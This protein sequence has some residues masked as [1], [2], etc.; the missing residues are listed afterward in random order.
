[1]QTIYYHRHYIS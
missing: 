1:M